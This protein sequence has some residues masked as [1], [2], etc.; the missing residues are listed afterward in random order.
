MRSSSGREAVP[1]TVGCEVTT[2]ESGRT[3]DTR[4]VRRAAV[5][6]GLPD[7]LDLHRKVTVKNIRSRSK[8]NLPPNDALPRI[9]VNTD[10]VDVRIDGQPA[11]H[12]AR[13]ELPFRQWL[14]HVRPGLPHGRNRHGA[15]ADRGRPVKLA[16]REHALLIAL[17]RDARFH[18]GKLVERL[19][20]TTEEEAA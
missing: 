14:L 11:N 4:R 8:A 16:R 12:P 13:T 7:R 17:V 18:N 20:D 3:S 9:A 2:C 5:E 1:F 15:Q 19:D 6:D 10:T